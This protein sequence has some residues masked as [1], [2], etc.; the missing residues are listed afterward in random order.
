MILTLLAIAWILL[1]LVSTLTLYAACAMAKRHDE[2]HGQNVDEAPTTGTLT[3]II[4]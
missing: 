4:I 1:S 2:Q 3:T